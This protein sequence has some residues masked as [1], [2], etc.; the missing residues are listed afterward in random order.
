MK[1]SNWSIVMGI[2]GLML[3]G[4]SVVRYVVIYEDMSSLMIFVGLGLS[5][6]G[7]AYIY[8]RLLGLGNRLLAVEDYITDNQIK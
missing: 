2:A 4:A 8:N 7:F 1:V 6:C 5:L 3:I